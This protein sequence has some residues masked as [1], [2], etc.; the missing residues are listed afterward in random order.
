M[1]DLI[2][3]IY[4][5]FDRFPADMVGIDSPKFTHGRDTCYALYNAFRSKLPSELQD[6]FDNLMD[7]QLNSLIAGQE[8]GFVSGFK[9]GVRLMTE[10]LLPTTQ[11]AM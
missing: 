6:D 4:G 8:E 10:A 9:I 7:A 3:Q 5:G 1:E 11:E 2:R